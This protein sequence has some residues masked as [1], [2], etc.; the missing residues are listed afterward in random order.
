MHAAVRDDVLHVLLLLAVGRPVDAP[1]TRFRSFRGSSVPPVVVHRSAQRGADA[2]REDVVVDAARSGLSRER[3]YPGGLEPRPLH[4]PPAA[5]RS[6]SAPA[7]IGAIN[8]QAH[9]RWRHLPF[10]RSVSRQ[11]ITDGIMILTRALSE[12]LG[13]VVGL[14][15]PSRAAARALC[16]TG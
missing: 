7:R 1:P 5:C 3:P 6:A 10:R 11:T 9:D 13:L 4:S 16:G 2:A 14:E 8:G 12:S 15:A